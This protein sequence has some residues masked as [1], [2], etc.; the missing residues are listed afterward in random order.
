M[1]GDLV[2]LC[3]RM[4]R[5]LYK[6]PRQGQWRVRSHALCELFVSVRQILLLGVFSHAVAREKKAL[7]QRTAVVFSTFS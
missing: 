7:W 5:L 1:D 2:G 3:V 4:P 6:L